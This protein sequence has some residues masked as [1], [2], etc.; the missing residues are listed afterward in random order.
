M[1]A[2]EISP[3]TAMLNSAK[4]AFTARR[5]HQADAVSIN[6]DIDCA[7]PGD[8]VLARVAELGSHKRVQ[9]TTGRPSDLYCDD[10][11]VAACA[12]RY[13]SDQFEGTARLKCATADLLAGGGCIG[14]MLNKHQSKRQPTRVIPVGLLQDSR[15]DI[16]NLERYALGA[17]NNR[18]KP[19]AI[20]VVGAAM[21]SGKTTAAASLV[22]GLKCA[23]HHVAALKATGTGAFGDFNTYTDAGAD[24]VADFTDAGMAST[25]ME[26]IDRIKTGLNLLLN[27]A[28]DR[29]CDVAVVEFA[30]GVLQQ[31]TAELLGTHSV[32]SLFES[33][34]YATGDSLSALGGVVQLAK[35]GLQPAALTGTLSLSPLAAREA[36]EAT[37]LQVLSREQLCDPVCASALAHASARGNP[38]VGVELAA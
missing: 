32:T 12:A 37:S 36:T 20:A 38:G 9:L 35:L 34:V 14:T 27:G 22:H 4:W 1:K 7:R 28:M 13:A 17:Q 25:Y 18:S 2:L 24:F 19:R 10:L 11:V 33:F 21:N 16:I 6:K 30:D 5:V 26:S 23:G 31:E 3:V 29:G 8:L 15:G